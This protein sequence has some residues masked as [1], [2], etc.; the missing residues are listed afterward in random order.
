MLASV[1]PYD[2]GAYPTAKSRIR[3]RSLA[4]Y[5]HHQD[6]F[7]GNNA[8]N[9]H[10]HHHHQDAFAGITP[11]INTSAKARHHQLDADTTM[12]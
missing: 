4:P 3:P 10:H 8:A 5:C 7:V 2:S 6:A 9:H 11:Q 1:G 12:R